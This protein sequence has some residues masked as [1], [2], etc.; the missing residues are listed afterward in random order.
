M[1]ILLEDPDL[2]IFYFNKLRR[3]PSLDE[4]TKDFCSVSDALKGLHFALWDR[5]ICMT[6]VPPPGLGPVLL[7]EH[8][9]FILSGW[10][11]HRGKYQLQ[12]ASLY[13]TGVTLDLEQL[14]ITMPR[15]WFAKIRQVST[16]E[17][18]IEGEGGFFDKALPKRLE[19]SRY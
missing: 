10:K 19:I 11:G 9:P 7:H 17:H 6:L 16:P 5:S 4:I 13:H 3:D 1:T 18:T 12:Y 2:Q 14:M 15:P 8:K